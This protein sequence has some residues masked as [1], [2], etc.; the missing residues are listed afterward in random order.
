MADQSQ[1][2]KSKT[3]EILEKLNDKRVG[4]FCD[5]ANL[6]YGRQK[7]GWQISFEKFKKFIG[8]YCDLQFINYY[9]AIPAKNDNA[10]YGTQRFLEKIEPFVDVKSKE[11]RYILVGGQLLKKGNMDIEIVLD[12]VR[13]INN[14]DTVIVMSGDSDFLELKNYIVKEKHKNI[15][16]FGYEKN[17]GW[18]LRQCRHIYLERIKDEIILD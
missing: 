4:L 11:L 13:T 3:K 18:E 17:M 5:G 6:F 16:F 1:N 12:V 14:L 2:S 15:I 10:F 7:Y 9:L 8:R